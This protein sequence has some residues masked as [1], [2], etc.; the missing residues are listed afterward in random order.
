MS[1][2]PS[3]RDYFFTRRTDKTIVSRSFSD[4]SGNKLRIASHIVDGQEGLQFAQVQDEILLRRTP[5]GRYEIKAT[6]LE[7]DRRIATLTIQRY[8]NK[9]PL[10]REAFSFVG[11][12]IDTLLDFVA[13]IKSIALADATK[14][15]I[16]DEELREII[17]NRGQAQRIFA[18]NEALFLEIA[19]QEDLTRDLVAI[20]Y[21]RKQLERFGRLLS[22]PEYFANEKIE[23]G[24][25]R[26]E[27]VWQV[28]FQENTWI[29]GYGLSFQFVSELSDGKLEQVVR[30]S[31]VSGRGKRAD[32][33]MKTRGYIN[34]L[35]FVEIKRHDTPLLGAQFRSEAWGPS[36]DLAG[37]VAQVQAT[38]QTALENFGR[39]LTT[40]EKDGTPTG[41]LLF[42]VEPRSCLV[43]G[44]L[45]EFVTQNGIN[46]SKFR[47]FELYRRNTWRPEIVTFDE[48]LERARF[49]VLHGEHAVAAS[50]DEQFFDL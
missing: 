22:D 26:P 40:T 8:S 29:F 12:E 18:K 1:D 16:S 7:D 39:T 17:L 24:V 2:E 33:L 25:R 28:F 38:V 30:G 20:G 31:D 21:R 41:E 9:R 27:D 37:G 5:S 19:Q 34:S 48:L 35:C 4:R 42:N 11:G 46:E 6:F 36:G 45:N 14:R 44:S 15:H 23:L 13:G 43:I 50:S 47:S 10:G 49:I 32:A 3:D